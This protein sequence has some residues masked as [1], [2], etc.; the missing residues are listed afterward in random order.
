MGNG[1]HSATVEHHDTSRVVCI[2]GSRLGISYME[3]HALLMGGTLYKGPMLLH[4]RNEM[5]EIRT[6]NE[7]SLAGPQLL[8]RLP[9][10]EFQAA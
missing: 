4:R 10:Q 5:V 7:G 9:V 2:L 8:A 3:L 1:K 6:A